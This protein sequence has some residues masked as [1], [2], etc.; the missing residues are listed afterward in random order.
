MGRS[1]S[2]ARRP[3]AAFSRLESTWGVCRGQLLLR[4]LGWLGLLMAVVAA[5]AVGATG[6]SLERVLQSDESA[7]RF[8][9]DQLAPQ[10][11][12]HSLRGGELQLHEVHIPGFA[13]GGLPA[14]PKLPR[15]G[16]WVVLPPGMRPVLVVVAEEW[17]TLIPRP[18]MVVPTPVVLIDSQ[19]Q[20]PILGHELLLP[21]ES[22]RV[23]RPLAVAEM[24]EEAAGR[25]AALGGGA[26]SLGD[27]TIWRGRRIVPYTIAPVRIDGEGRATALLEGGTWEI[28]FVPDRSGAQPAAASVRLA[29]TT[30]RGDDRFSAV[31]LNGS[32]LDRWPTEAAAA[33]ESFKVDS[34]PGGLSL[35]RQVQPLVPEVKLPVSR[36]RLQRVTASGLR[37]ANLLPAIAIQES[38]IRLYQRRFIEGLSGPGGRS[39]VDVEVPIIMFGEG[40]EF[41]GDDFFLFYGLRPRDDGEFTADLGQGDVNVPDCGDRNENYNGSNIYWLAAAEPPAGGS[42]AR[43][44]VQTLGPAVGEPLETY[45]R[46]DYFEE[47]FAYQNQIADKDADRNRWNDYN[48]SEINIR[49]PVFAAAP[50]AANGQ[51]RIGYMGFANTTSSRWHNA[52]MINGAGETLLGTYNA[53]TNVEKIFTAP[54]TGAQLTDQEVTFHI[55]RTTQIRLFS[56]VDWLEVSYD[57]LYRA[58]FDTL[59]F[60][61]GD[62]VGDRDIEV[63]GFRTADLGLIEISDPHHPVWVALAAENISGAAKDW[64]LSLR[65]PQPDG[66]RTFLADSKMSSDGVTEFS[67]IFAK[68][69]TEEVDPTQVSGPPDLVVITHGDFRDAI[70]RWV[71][72]RRARAGG[73][74]SVH[75]VNVADIYDYFGGG[76]KGIQPVKRFVTYAL[77]EWG[78]WALQIVG[79]ANENARSLGQPALSPDWYNL[80]T[81]WIPTHLHVQDLGFPFPPELLFSDKW[82]ATPTAGPNYPDDT[83]VPTEMYVGRFPCNNLNQ[84]NN[85]IDKTIV[86]ETVQEAQP[87]RRRGIFF[88]DDAWSY[89]YENAFGDSTTY[90]ESEEGFQDSEALMGGW[91]STLGLDSVNVFLSESLDGLVQPPGARKRDTFEFRQY[92][93]DYTWPRLTQ[94]MNAGATIVHFQGH[95]NANVLTHE[96]IWWD[97]FNNRRDVSALTNR[98]RPWVFFGMGCHIS[99]WAQNTVYGPLTTLEPSLGEKMLVYRNGGAV[100]SYGSSGFEY[101]GPNSEFSEAQM[102]RFIFT[103]PTETVTAEEI[104]SRWVL[105]ELLWAAESDLLALTYDVT[106]H[107][108]MVAQYALLGDALLALNC[109]PPDVTALLT[110]ASGDTL[111]SGDHLLGLD[112]ANLRLIKLETFDETGIDRLVI[113]GPDPDYSSYVSESIPVGATTHRRVDYDVSLPIRPLDH[114]LTLKV[115]DTTSP[116]ASDLAT[117]LSV[118]CPQNAIFYLDGE[119]IEPESLELQ[120]GIP[121]DLTAEV[122]SSAYLNPEWVMAL[123]GH[124]L[125]LSNVSI[126]QRDVHTLDLSFTATPVALTTEERAVVLSV[127]GYE[128][129]YPFNQPAAAVMGLGA[130]YAFPNPLREATRFVIQTDLP[131]SRGRIEIYSV[132]GRP[133]ASLKIRPTDFSDEQASLV[134]WDGRDGEGDFLANGVY[135]YRVHLDGPTGTVTSDMQRLVIMR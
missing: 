1:S 20:E 28:R 95:A 79:D 53:D 27:V 42:W 37:N 132:A 9:L 68:V 12:Q 52:S 31:F 127:D 44:S 25:T 60:H 7:V 5:P 77:N 104:R 88:A 32:M 65:V 114:V 109:G 94:M 76:L 19:T 121:I 16:G 47:D 98:E 70:G 41:A 91:W 107:R 24:Q 86:Y 43:M 110:D 34:V 49:V 128:S 51:L 10:W 14:A 11:S 111:R 59:L 125:D 120:V 56:Y 22:P 100:A 93:Y 8:T 134:S 106:R 29:K 85:I 126:E 102:N 35:Q 6:S 58:R 108:R 3:G 40:D 78:S 74:L 69:K 63:T 101:L 80:P 67:Y 123:T 96:F 45:R 81:D 26:V 46:V 83:G 129:V 18:L 124:S 122:T 4:L 89:G 113:E 116:V 75:V 92:A 61:G 15:R 30:T 131:P 48:E 118:Q 54:L 71:D 72:H 55:Q 103:P 2:T 119:V 135:L 105:G 112:P 82:F 84:L 117:A 36:T 130:I 115:Y 50:A 23:G 73:D 66:R 33:G 133:V 97:Q 62:V 64:R 99:D 57:A 13:A 87:W 21:G 17:E 38:Q 39:Y 90:K